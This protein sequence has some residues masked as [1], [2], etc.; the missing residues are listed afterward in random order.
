MSIQTL[1]KQDA[2]RGQ[3]AVAKIDTVSSTLHNHLGAQS[4]INIQVAKNTEDI[5][6]LR[7]NEER[8]IGDL[9]AVRADVTRV[10]N[11]L[12]DR[13]N[14]VLAWLGAVTPWAFVVLGMMA[15]FFVVNKGG[16]P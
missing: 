4:M 2:L 16:T 1:I 12:G 13:Q 3:W 8:R 6:V 11:I 14:K 9:Q 10:L 7:I 15:Y 5:V